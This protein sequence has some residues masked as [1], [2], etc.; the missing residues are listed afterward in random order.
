MLCALG[1]AEA[2]D[3]QRELERVTPPAAPS[4]EPT[5]PVQIPAPPAQAPSEAGPRFDVVRY[6]VEGNT[7]LTKDS[8]ASV[9]AP[10]TGKERNFADV[11]RARQA[12]QK[13]YV[14]SGFSAVLVIVPE[15]EVEAGVVRLKVIEGKIAQIKVEGNRFFD[16]QNIREGLPALRAGEAPNTRDVAANL[17]LTNENPAKKGNIVLKASETPNE[18]DATINVA[19]EK[20]WR[21][22]VTLDNSGTSQTT[23]GR[24][25]FAYQHANV[26]NLD[27][28]LSL[29]YTTSPEE[30]DAVT[31]FG[32]GYHIPLYSL[33]SSVDFFAGYA[34]V[35]SGAVADLFDVS[36]RGTIFGARF[37]QLLSKRGSYDH[38]LAYGLDY[39]S[40]ENDVRVQGGN[41]TLVPDITVHPAS[42]TYAGIWTYPQTKT[43][44]Y[45]TAAHNIKGGSDGQQEDFTAARAGADADYTLFRYGGNIVH[46]FANDVQLRLRLEGQLTNDALIPGEQFGLGGADSVRGFEEREITNDKGFHGGAEL[47][48]PDFGANLY[49][50]SS[51]RALVFYDAGRVS[52]NRSLPGE[53]SKTSIGSIG[54]GLRASVDRHVNFR[55]DYGYV[56]DG[57][58]GRD[59]GDARAHASLNIVF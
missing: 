13:A 20:F 12:L 41:E 14:D 25:S 2:A 4:V 55:L 5:P 21:A 9:V 27:H 53:I 47:Y 45:L 44:F 48:F 3:L 8:V 38:R 24:I 22:A 51:A 28:V 10:F 23:D 50:A 54:V 43:N 15:Q 1:N 59:E 16:E 36:G 40:Y 37:N 26:A 42:L 30:I 58:G 32:T 34:D 11:E 56:I 39:R 19:D 17:R 46:A 29:Q 52:R 31:V 33:Q 49:E 7:L 6:E 35:D 18:I 57:G